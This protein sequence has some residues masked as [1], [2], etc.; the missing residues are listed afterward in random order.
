MRWILR[1]PLA[2]VVLTVA[3][4]LLAAVLEQVIAVWLGPARWDWVK[5]TQDFVRNGFLAA[6]LAFLTSAIKNHQDAARLRRAHGRHVLGQGSVMALAMS[7]WSHVPSEDR[8]G[9]KPEDI[10][11]DRNS[12]ETLRTEA[13]AW[14]KTATGL[15]AVRAPEVAQ[16]AA[17]LVLQN[18]RWKLAGDY[19]AEGG[20][21]RRLI[22]LARLIDDLALV[23]SSP[24]TGMSAAAHT[25]RIRAT[26][27]LGWVH[28]TDTTIVERLLV[29]RSMPLTTL[30]LP[31]SSGL[32]SLYSDGLDSSAI[33]H[34][35]LYF[36]LFHLHGI[37]ETVD[38]NAPDTQ[39]IDLLLDQL[40]RI[41]GALVNEL[42]AAADVAEALVDL[43][44]HAM[45]I[46][47]SLAA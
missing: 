31:E 6:L 19:A 45:R 23:E 43:A 1:N 18:L 21:R 15:D 42:R 29:E 35:P 22:H 26:V 13:Q 38:L 34:D 8:E 24:D 25:F 7:G 27:L 11:I 3:F 20:R 47:G 41:V 14:R 2:L 10:R 4:A 9:A 28:H 33:S 12:V 37:C 16:L 5:V 39:R 17:F 46:D 32:F 40:R 36:L 44:E 30:D